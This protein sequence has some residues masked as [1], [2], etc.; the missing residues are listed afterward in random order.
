M[1]SLTTTRLIATREITGRIRSRLTW[2]MTA[3][4]TLLSSWKHGRLAVELH[5][6][7]DLILKE[8]TKAREADV[9]DLERGS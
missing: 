5:K 2:V 8:A 9:E 7:F 4:T 1:T 6:P 3:I